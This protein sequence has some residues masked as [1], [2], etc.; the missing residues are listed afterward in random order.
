MEFDSAYVYED[1][2]R[3]INFVHRSGLMHKEVL[4]DCEKYLVKN[5][6]CLCIM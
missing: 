5:V 4:Q 6:N 3:S 2:K 1:V